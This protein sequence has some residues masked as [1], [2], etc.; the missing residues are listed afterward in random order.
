M[1]WPCCGKH[2]SG[3]GEVL[4]SLYQPDGTF[5]P[6]EGGDW[7]PK[8]LSESDLDVIRWDG[9]EPGSQELSP[10]VMRNLYNAADWVGVHAEYRGE[11]HI[12]LMTPKLALTYI[13]QDRLLVKR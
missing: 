7:T 9:R 3:T 12:T 11:G 5:R 6:V 1:P 2:A 8:Q 13:P 10:S 4:H